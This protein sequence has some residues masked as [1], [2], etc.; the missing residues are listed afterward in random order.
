[1]GLIGLVRLVGKLPF[2]LVYYFAYG[3]VVAQSV[4]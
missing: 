4:E 1:M 2:G 3:L